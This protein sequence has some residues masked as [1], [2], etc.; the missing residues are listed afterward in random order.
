MDELALGRNAVHPARLV[1]YFNGC[2]V[3]SSLFNLYPGLRD[4][5][6]EKFFTRELN[7]DIGRF[8]AS[9]DAFILTEYNHQDI[10][11]HL[12]AIDQTL[13]VLREYWPTS[14]R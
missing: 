12:T 14:P 9:V 4:Y 1:T 5:L 6:N 7:T 13:S 8:M 11:A 10:G 3:F 2:S